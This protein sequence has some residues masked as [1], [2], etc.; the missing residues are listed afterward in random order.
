MAIRHPTSNSTFHNL[1]AQH[2]WRKLVPRPF[3]PKPQRRGSKRFCL[4][5]PGDSAIQVD[6]FANELAGDLRLL[7]HSQARGL[8]CSQ[9]THLFIR[10]DA[11]IAG[12]G[13]P[14]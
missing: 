10:V 8:L 1:L 7:N 14:R 9:S 13:G 6:V 3:H 5:E 4:Q 12:I 2:G 11:G